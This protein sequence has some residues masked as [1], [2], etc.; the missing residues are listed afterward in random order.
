V[1]DPKGSDGPSRR[2]QSPG[3][4]GPAALDSSAFG[5]VRF[6]GVSSGVFVAIVTGP[7]IAAL[8]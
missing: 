7:V 3:L 5:R 6:L 8:E 1:S 4:D 2:S